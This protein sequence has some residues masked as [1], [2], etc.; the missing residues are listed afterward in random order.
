M[1]RIPDCC[2]MSVVHFLLVFAINLG[3]SVAKLPEQSAATNLFERRILRL[4]FLL[5]KSFSKF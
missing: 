5:L 3:I 1:D 2:L 4:D